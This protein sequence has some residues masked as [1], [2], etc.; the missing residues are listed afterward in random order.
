MHLIKP[1]PKTRAVTLISTSLDTN[2]WKQL[3][4]PSLDIVVMQLTGDFGSCTLFNIYNDCIHNNTMKELGKYLESHVRQIR[5]SAHDH[6]ETTK[7]TQE[8]ALS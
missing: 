3:P 1:G 8:L 4:F 7:L 2:A 6:I 5:P